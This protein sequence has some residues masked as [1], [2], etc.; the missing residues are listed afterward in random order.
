MTPRRFVSIVLPHAIFQCSSPLARRARASILWAGSTFLLL[1]LLSAYC[2]EKGPTKARDPEFAAK[3]ERLESRLHEHPEEPLIL[4]LGSSRTLLMLD[5]GSMHVN[6]DAKTA[7]VFNFG[8]KGSGPL[9]ELLTLER[10][11]K[12]GVRP[13]L[14]LL[15]VFPAL[16]N[17]PVDRSLEEIWFQEGRLRHAEVTELRPYHS[18]RRRIWRRWLRFRLQPWGGIERTLEDY[19][20]PLGPDHPDHHGDYDQTVIDPFGWEPHFR[21]GIS[22]A[23]REH[24]REVARTQY[25]PAMGPYE[26]ASNAFAALDAI[27]D[28][29]KQIDLPVVMVL[30]PEGP[31]FRSFYPPEMQEQF[32]KR[33][34]RIS[35]DR[36]VLLVNARDW[37]TEQEL[38]DSHHALPAGAARFSH[39]LQEEILAP[40]MRFLS[41][42]NDRRTAQSSAPPDRTN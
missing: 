9:L 22:D 7:Q 14:L 30:M 27:L 37:L 2:V 3:F 31:Y 4:M 5:A 33:F 36:S 16:Y 20:D 25:H 17:R 34:A 38:Y 8:M 42:R 19:L 18:N 40:V 32:E 28:T 26:P 35:K 10:L 12:S 24:Y 15:E 21:A 13:D 6:W 29:C 23:Q 1:Y 41:L 39:R 11:L